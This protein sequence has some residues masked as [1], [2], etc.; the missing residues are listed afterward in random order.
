MNRILRDCHWLKNSPELLAVTPMCGLNKELQASSIPADFY[1]SESHRLGVY[2][3]QLWQNI[4]ATNSAFTTQLH[5]QQVIIDKHT[6]GEFDSLLRTANGNYYHCEMAVKFYLQIGQEKKQTQGKQLS[7]WVG[8]NLKDRFDLK[9]R[10]LFD[11]QLQLAQHTPVKQWLT[12]RNIHVEQTK[13][14]TRGR[15]FYPIERFL[16]QEFVFPEQV[17]PQHLKGFWIVAGQLANFIK[18]YDFEWYWLDKRYWLGDIDSDDIVSENVS[19]NTRE[20]VGGNIGGN[21]G[22]SIIKITNETLALD[23]L[24]KEKFYRSMPQI[25]ALQQEKEV[26]RGFVVSEQWLDK[27]KQRVAQ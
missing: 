1:M 3:E 16:A 5:N 8:P 12:Q 25:V 9:Y 20:S 26:M 18:Q 7:D 24:R 23:Y 27:A 4:I 6:Y 13:L 21:I 19:E 10:R 17:N 15:L 22:D 2:F 14:L 11:H